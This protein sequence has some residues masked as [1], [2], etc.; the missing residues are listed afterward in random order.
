[1]AFT[2]FIPRQTR[3]AGIH[4]S[5]WRTIPA[6]TVRVTL[7]INAAWTAADDVA[8]LGI[9]VS[10]DGGLTHNPFAFAPV[11]GGA[12][13]KE[14]MLPSLT[15]K[16][17]DTSLRYRMFALLAVSTEIGLDIEVV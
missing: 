14:G 1:M 3:S 9:E 10:A 5:A 17:P 8:L 11:Y 15:I 12:R 2:T 7:R 13:D 16:N 6:G 4:R